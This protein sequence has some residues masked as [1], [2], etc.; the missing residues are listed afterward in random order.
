MGFISIA[1]NIY[2]VNRDSGIKTNVISGAFGR[3][4][5]SK[6]RALS[7]RN[8]NYIQ[9]KL[10]TVIFTIQISLA[11][12]NKK[13][14]NNLASEEIVNWWRIYSVI[15]RAII[16]LS[17]VLLPSNTRSFLSPVLTSIVR[18]IVGA[19]GNL[20]RDDKTV[21]TNLEKKVKMI[22]CHNRHLYLTNESKS[23][24]VIFLPEPTCVIASYI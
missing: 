17:V 12:W 22:F 4:V 2:S 11:G 13:A 23:S 7:G 16:S 20:F 5:R 19:Q 24:L 8:L 6:C 18:K 3:Q 15:N 14:S 9:W 10:Q 21:A 1:W